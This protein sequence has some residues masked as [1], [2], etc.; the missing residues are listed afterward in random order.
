M[1]RCVLQGVLC[2]CGRLVLSLQLSAHGS[3]Q[4]A[5]YLVR[6][7]LLGISWAA[8]LTVGYVLYIFGNKIS[9]TY[10]LLQSLAVASRG[11]EE[12]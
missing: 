5:S 8:F 10:R 1:T 12:M 4:E 6:Y 7:G 9:A 2:A 11:I 3:G